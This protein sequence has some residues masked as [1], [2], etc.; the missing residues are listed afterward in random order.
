MR[1]VLIS[2]AVAAAVVGSAGAALAVSGAPNAPA[3]ARSNT[4]SA[5]LTTSHTLVNVHPHR[6]AVRCPSGDTLIR[7]NITGPRG[8]SGV[9]S[10]KTK[11]LGNVPSVATGGGFVAN[12]TEV[13]QVQLPAGTYLLSLNAKATPNAATSGEVFP[14]FFVYNQVKNADF[15]GDLFNVGTGALEPAATNHDSYFSGSTTITLATATTLRVYAF[16]YDS[17]S[18]AGSYTLDD[19]TV[20]ATRVNPG[21]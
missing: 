11:D 21:E 18:G 19:L 17:D 15:T 20:T 12:S 2:A 10:T 4:I 5:C 1:K 7:W 6:V 3:S 13:G 14:Q 16:G 9:V 8:P